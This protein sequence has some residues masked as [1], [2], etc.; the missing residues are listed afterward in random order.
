MPKQPAVYVMASARN[1]TLYVGVTSDLVARV[2][3][4]RNGTHRGF[5]KEYGVTT[6]VYYETHA[7]MPDAIRREKQLKRWNR[8]W[9]IE[10]VEKANPA[11]DDLWPEISG[12]QN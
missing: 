5:T 12:D 4:H 1:G 11:W 2:W 10:L 3:Q 9:K 8:A 6:L 7:T